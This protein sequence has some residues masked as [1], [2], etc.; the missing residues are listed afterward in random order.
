MTAT[1]MAT[2]TAGN[3]GEPSPNRVTMSRLFTSD[4]FTSTIWPIT[5]AITQVAAPA[6]NMSRARRHRR[7]N[8]A[9]TATSPTAQSAPTAKT[10]SKNESR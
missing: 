10:S 5:R 1:T 7:A 6:M 2:R 3:E 9:A 4:W 8:S